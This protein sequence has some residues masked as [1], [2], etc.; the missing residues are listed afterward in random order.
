MGDLL[1][2]VEIVLDDLARTGRGV[3]EKLSSGVDGSVD[4]GMDAVTDDGSELA[5]SGVDEGTVDHAAMVFPVV[6][7]VRG[8]GAGT[9]VDLGA[10]HGVADVREMSDVGV[11]ADDGVLDLDG[12]SDVAVV[13]DRGIAAEVTV[14]ADLAVLSDDDV[15]FDVNAGKDAGSFSD[16]SESID[17]G[18]RVDVALD[19]LLY[20]RI[21]IGGERGEVKFIGSEQIPFVDDEEGSGCF[22]GV[23][24]GWEITSPRERSLPL[25]DKGSVAIG[26]QLGEV[27]CGQPCVGMKLESRCG[28]SRVMLRKADIADGEVFDVLILEKWHEWALL[29]WD[30]DVLLDGMAELFDPQVDGAGIAVLDE[31]A[32]LVFRAGVA[33]QL[34]A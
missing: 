33:D 6:T 16:L 18:E 9:E 22:E 8:H 19:V 10:K 25:V 1:G 5:A 26:R 2:L 4:A 32:D 21:E 20:Q 13:A 30:S 27:R 34:A 12:L 15:S 17:D 23:F 29:G 14:R 3:G 24:F 11:R 28:E 7:K 31:D